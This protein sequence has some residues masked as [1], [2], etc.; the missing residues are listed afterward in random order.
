MPFGFCRLYWGDR[1]GPPLGLLFGGGLIEPL[2][3]KGVYEWAPNCEG[4][5]CD[6]WP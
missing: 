6:D 2:G 1:G 4:G 3:T 5:G